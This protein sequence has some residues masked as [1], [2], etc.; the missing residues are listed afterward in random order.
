VGHRA[1]P[2]DGHD[3]AVNA[4]AFSPDGRHMFSGSA[5][6]AL[7]LWDVASGGSRALVGTTAGVNALNS[8]SR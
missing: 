2:L 5:D 1:L 4:V 8:R 7:R 6:C 3:R